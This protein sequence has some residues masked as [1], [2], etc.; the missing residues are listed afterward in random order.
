MTHNPKDA[1]PAPAST[2]SSP[3]TSSGASGSVGTQMLRSLA[4]GGFDLQM[5]ALAPRAAAPKGAPVQM[6]AAIGNNY[7]Q[8]ADV[9]DAAVKKVVDDP[10]PRRFKSRGE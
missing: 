1:A 8:P 9:K 6:K 5:K 2:S 7:Q 10:T 3:A 4:P